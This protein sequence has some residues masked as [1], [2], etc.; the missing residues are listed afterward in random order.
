MKCPRFEAAPDAPRPAR[1]SPARPDYS[2]RTAT[3]VAPRVAPSGAV[4]RTNTRL[5]AGSNGTLPLPVTK[6]LKVG[7]ALVVMMVLTLG[8]GVCRHEPL[9]AVWHSERLT[10]RLAAPV[11]AVTV[12]GAEAPTLTD[13]PY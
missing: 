7:V 3:L 11:S 2:V 9:A 5:L 8:P 1:F 10:G 13:A 4:N 12:I 6:M